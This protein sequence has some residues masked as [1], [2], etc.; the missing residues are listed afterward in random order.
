MSPLSPVAPLVTDGGRRTWPPGFDGWRAAAKPGDTDATYTRSFAWSFRRQRLDWAV[1]IPVSLYEYC[2][3]RLRTGQY[4]LYLADPFQQSFVESLVDRLSDLGQDRRDRITAAVRFVQSLDY[5]RDID[6]T[7]HEAYPKYPVETLVHQ[8]GDCEDGTILL[9]TMLRAMGCD[10]AVLA[11]PDANHMILGL[12]CEWGSG[13]SVDHAG[14]T[15]YTVET[16]SQ[17]RDVGDLPPAYRDTPVQVHRPENHPVLVHEW[18]ATPRDGR[19]VGIEA[20][21]ANFGDDRADDVHL[22]IEFERR[23]GQTVA[24]RP[25]SGDRTALRPGESARYEGAVTL[26]PDRTLRGKCLVAIGRTLHD[27]S[28]SDWR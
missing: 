21:A 12:A 7:G 22:R 16:T 19:R 4:G 1:E 9:G 27:V 5:T 17:G 23:D 3:N 6:D 14:R 18:E 8:Q 10:V 13:A 2:T 20:H 11:L 24:R 26:P 15:Y 25:L 28:E